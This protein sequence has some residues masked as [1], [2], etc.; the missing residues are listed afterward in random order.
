MNPLNS[1]I[2]VGHRKP[3]NSQERRRDCGG[4]NKNRHFRWV[5]LEASFK[6]VS[7][8]ATFEAAT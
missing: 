6:G 4:L 7:I 8:R 1:S 2:L 3:P 5:S